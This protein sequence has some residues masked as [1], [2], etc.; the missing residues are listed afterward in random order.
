MGAGEGTGDIPLLFSVNALL[1]CKKRKSI[2]IAHC[3]IEFN[4]I[5]IHEAVVIL[6]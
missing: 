2:V 3:M 5:F 1:Q 6:I 4:N